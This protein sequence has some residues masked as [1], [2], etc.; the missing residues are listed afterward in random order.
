MKLIKALLGLAV[1]LIV[2]LAVLVVVAFMYIDTAVKQGVERGG[3]YA[4]QVPVTL[5]NADLGVFAGTLALTGLEVANPPGYDAPNFLSLQ[6]AAVSLDTSTIN[7]PVVTLPAFNLSDLTINLQRNDQRPNYAVILDNLKR[8]STGGDAQPSPEGDAKKVIIN[9]VSLRNITVNLDLLP[10]GGELT[11]THVKLDEVILNNIGTASNGVTVSEATAIIVK[12]LMSVIAE[13]AGDLFPAELLTDLQ[14]Q[15][16]SLDTLGAGLT[17][18]IS[19][20][21]QKLGEDLTNQAQDAIDDAATKAKDAVDN[22]AEDLEE[23]A[24]EGIGN[25]LPGQKKDD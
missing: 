18:A 20:D 19:G 3:S 5:D 15:L 2:L 22:A 12:A 21:I 13:T 4:L 8:L 7:Q 6:N 24:R 1:G 17:T 14:S 25:L 10:A 11:N 16:A 9:Q 23:K